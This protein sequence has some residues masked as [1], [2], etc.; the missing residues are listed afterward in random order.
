MERSVA[1]S[2]A[3][4]SPNSVPPPQKEESLNPIESAALALAVPPRKRAVHSSPSAATHRKKLKPHVPFQ[5]K[6]EHEAYPKTPAVP[7]CQVEHALSETPQYQ[8]DIPSF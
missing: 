4:A 6:A 1:D 7:T 8:T 3:R 5:G 2:R